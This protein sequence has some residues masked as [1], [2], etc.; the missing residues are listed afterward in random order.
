MSFV[1][2]VDDSHSRFQDMN[3]ADGF[4]EILN[5]QHP[6]IK[7]T[8]EKE[9]D[10]KELQFL[11]IKVMNKGTEKYEFDV[12]RKNAITNVQVKP[13]SGHDP[14]ILRGI[15]KGFLNRA[16]AICSTKYLNEEM[17][18]L[19]NI[20]V[21]NGYKRDDLE[22]MVKEIKSKNNEEETVEQ[23]PK[24]DTHP[25]Q[26]I[27]LPWIPGVSTRLRKVYRKAGY[28]VVFKSG[29]SIGSILTSRNKDKLPKNSYPGVYRIPCSC[30][31]TPYRGHTKKKVNS[32]TKQHEAD[33]EKQR[34]D[35]S[36]IAMH[37]K[38]C[39]GRI[40]FENTETVAVETNKFNRT[41]REA[42]EIQKH[43]CF[44]KDGGMN[45]DRG[46]YVTTKFWIPMLYYLKKQENA[47]QGHTL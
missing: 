5:Q 16:L 17:D 13:Q 19:V 12:F 26:T 22:K 35:N 20:F 31:I 42:L 45:K 3:S 28:K 33:V 29:K 2:Y 24:E 32:R 44:L 1:R 43:D 18:F 11:D 8:I 14:R 23:T 39:K 36:A 41:V 10:E 25:K 38:N 7:Y 4:L 6:K 30:G 21:E 34:W 40:E 37:S 15:F 46:Q 47:R 9:T 27:T